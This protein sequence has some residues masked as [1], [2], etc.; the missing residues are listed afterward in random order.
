MSDFQGLKDFQKRLEDIS[1][2]AQELNGEHTVSATELFPTQFMK[3]H[4]AVNSLEE[5]LKPLGI[6]GK[7]DAD[8][9]KVS[10]QDLD[11]LVKAKSDFSSWEEMK[12]AAVHKYLEKQ[13]F[14][15]R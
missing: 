4:T 15:T 9:N 11:S 6:S 13:L 10:Q 3:T 1:K 8:I 5:F 2:N 14:R 12:S 7:S